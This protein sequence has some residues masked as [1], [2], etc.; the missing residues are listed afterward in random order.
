MDRRGFLKGLA[1][2]V[3]GVAL[4]QAVP[5]GRVWS[6]PKEIKV[7]PSIQYSNYFGGLGLNPETLQIQRLHQGIINMHLD[8]L[9]LGFAEYAPRVKT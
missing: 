9:A 3:G 4:E 1:A 6:F 8:Q 7:R 2:L 5:L